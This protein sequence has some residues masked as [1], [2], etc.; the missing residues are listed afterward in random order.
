MIKGWLAGWLT[1]G[2]GPRARWREQNLNAPGAISLT[3]DFIRGQDS[4]WP[5]QWLT[6]CEHG[7]DSCKA[8]HLHLS[9]IFAPDICWQLFAAA[10]AAAVV[11]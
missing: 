3:T 11:Q 1:D 8:V 4:Q 5:T 9:S 6:E 7:K 2:L 10:A